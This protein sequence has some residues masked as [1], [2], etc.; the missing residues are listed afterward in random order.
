MK[1][2]NLSLFLAMFLSLPVVK[3]LS[4]D[5]TEVTGFG[6]NPGNLQ[7]F[8]Y[9]PADMPAGSPLVVVAHGC[10]QTAQGFADTSGWI[11]LANTYDF[12]LIFPQTST[13]NEPLAGCFRTWEPAHQ[14]RGSGEPLSVKQM[15]DY[16]VSQ[17]AL[18]PAKVFMTG[19]S[20]GGHLTNVMLATYPDAI[21]AGA[22]QSSFPYKCA[23]QLKDLASCSNGSKNLTALQWGDLARSGY[24]DY[25]GAR[26]RVQ[27]W[28][29]SVDPL[30]YPSTQHEQLEQWASVH[31]IDVIADS[32]EKLVGHPR[33]FYNTDAGGNRVQTVTIQ[34]LGHA[35]AVDPGSDAGQCGATG[36]YAEDVNICA[37]YWIGNFFGVT[38]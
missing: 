33:N 13:A 24:P 9:V 21:A 3:A 1:R 22:P 2:L 5:L 26:P 16:M 36:A 8:Q 19:M 30:I 14:E 15:I 4:T 20:S 29:G 35:I 18:S 28:H 34:G 31:G 17:Y 11:Q 37:A 32:D 10:T 23:M 38:Q 7:L 27:I 12:A 25:N 6:S